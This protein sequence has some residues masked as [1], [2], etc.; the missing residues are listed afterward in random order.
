MIKKAL[1]YYN[2]KPAG[3]L[4]KTDTGYLFEYLPEY[5]A[6]PRAR[7]VSLSLPINKVKFE[8]EILFPFFEGLLPEGWL[9]DITSKA[10]KIERE[11]KFEL[12]LKVGRDTA[13]AVSVVS[14]E[15]E[16]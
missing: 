11:N 13:G 4:S 10:L 5:A 6:L 12:L 14:Q 16:E 9:L 7:P 15:E 8:S 2:D 3:I 1:V